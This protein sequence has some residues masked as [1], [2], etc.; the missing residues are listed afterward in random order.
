[1]QVFPTTRAGPVPEAV[2]CLLA[3]L[4]ACLPACL[5]VD[6][7]L[8]SGPPCLASWKTICLVSQQLDNMRWVLVVSPSFTQKGKVEWEVDLCEGGREESKG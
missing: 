4:S 2:A 8:L 7:I 3:Y 6:S 1:M 5:P